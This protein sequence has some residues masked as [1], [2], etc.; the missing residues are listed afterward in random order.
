MA[1]AHP[2][3][4]LQR[5]GAMR[6]ASPLAAAALVQ[7]GPR[8]NDRGEA[9]EFRH[10]RAGLRSGAHRIG[11]YGTDTHLDADPLRLAYNLIRFTVRSA[12]PWQGTAAAVNHPIF[13]VAIL[14]LSNRAVA[15]C[16]KE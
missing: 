8:C 3:L 15:C 13:A 2:R 1:L 14:E 16:Q 10:L 11:G 6:K 5:A 9:V 12:V 7:W 4:K